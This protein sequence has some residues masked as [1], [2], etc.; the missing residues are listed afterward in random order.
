MLFRL[1][2]AFAGMNACPPAT[3]RLS[4]SMPM[5][6]PGEN[7]HAILPAVICASVRFGETQSPPGNS[8]A[9]IA[10]GASWHAVEAPRIR[11]R[12]DH[13]AVRAAESRHLAHKTES[14]L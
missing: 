7:G 3:T 8:D 11:E 5:K 12:L 9:L 10:A 6:S 4:R 2:T 14:K 1:I 13:A